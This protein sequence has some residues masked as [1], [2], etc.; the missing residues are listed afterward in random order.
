MVA[1][2]GAA[3]ED[4]AVGGWLDRIGVVRD[5]AGDDGGLAAVAD[6]GATG[7][8]AT[9]TS[10]ASAS[11]SRLPYSVLQATARL[12]RLNSIV[13]PLPGVP[14]GRWGDRDGAESMPGVWPGAGPNS[15][16]WM[17]PGSRPSSASAALVSLMNDAGPQR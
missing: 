11:S 12:L 16:T 7:P 2:L 14:A 17:R 15:S 10:H 9:G 13:G 4:G 3:D 1:R 8:A 5:G 6:T